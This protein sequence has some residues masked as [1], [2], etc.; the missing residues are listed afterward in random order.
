[1]LSEKLSKELDSEI[2]YK[3]LSR[4]VKEN[5]NTRKIQEKTKIDIDK[6]LDE[7]NSRVEGVK[8][9]LIKKI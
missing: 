6:A 2:S 7:V 4:W 8:I 3:Y 5:K 9:E 1:M